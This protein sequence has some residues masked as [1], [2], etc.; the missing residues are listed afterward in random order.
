MTANTSKPPGNATVPST[1]PPPFAPQQL[2]ATTPTSTRQE[3]EQLLADIENCKQRLQGVNK[4]QINRISGFSGVRLL[5]N[6]N[7]QLQI[8]P[9]AGVHV[10][11][12]VL[13]GSWNNTPPCSGYIMVSKASS[14]ARKMK[15]QCPKEARAIINKA[16]STQW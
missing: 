11:Y 12:L 9:I 1:D 13:P 16:S 3:L 7:V 5:A 15:V 10:R 14:K 8:L 2:P 4:N 6:A